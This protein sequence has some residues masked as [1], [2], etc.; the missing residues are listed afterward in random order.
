MQAEQQPR[1]GRFPGP[2][3]PDQG[4][5]LAG[6]DPDPDAVQDRVSPRR[7]AVGHVLEFD[8]S[9]ETARVP[10]SAGF[11]RGFQ[12]I[13]QAPQVGAQGLELEHGP[14]ERP[15]GGREQALEREEGHERAQ[16]HPVGQDLLA[17]HGE[18]QQAGHALE[19]TQ[20]QA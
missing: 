15:H 2:G 9:L 17:A 18:H 20:E 3:R 4:H 7:V 6:R 12:H 14:H 16:G 8:G 10:G 11:D 13:V 1:Q 19:Q 5:L